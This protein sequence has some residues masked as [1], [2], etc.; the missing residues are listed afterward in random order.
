MLLKQQEEY[1]TEKK[2]TD[3]KKNITMIMKKLV[4][5]FI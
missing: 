5:K 4:L 1:T 2:V 3:L